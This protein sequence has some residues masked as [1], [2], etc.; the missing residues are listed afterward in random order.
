MPLDTGVRLGPYEIVAPISADDG[1]EVYKAADTEQNRTVTIKLLPP[2]L[3]N[4]SELRQRFEGE[5]KA[6]SGLSHPHICTMYD[7]RREADT[8]FLVMEYVEGETLAKRLERGALPLDEALK[9]AID[10]TD[11][12][13]RAHTAGLVHLSLRPSN[14]MLTQEGPKLLDFGM[15]N[16]EPPK[17]QG[18]PPTTDVRAKVTLPDVPDDIVRYMAPEQV[19]GRTGDTRSDIFTFGAILYEM[20]TDEKAFEGRNRAMLIAAI[21]SLDPY[22]L[23]K[24]QPDSPPMLDH[25]AQRCLAKDPDGRWQTAHDLLVQMRWVAEGG[26]VLLAAARARRKRE[27]RVLVVLA[28][29]LFL[30][31]VTAVQAVVYWGGP[32]ETETFQFRVPVAGLN[33]SD[34]AISPDGKQLAV[35]AKPNTQDAAA[36]F[37]RPTGATEFHRLIG[38]E[39][40][41]QPFW[42]PDSR[43]IG[44]TAGGRLKRVEAAG[45]APKDLGEAP[46]FTGGAWGTAGV[47]LFGS[48]KGLYRVSAEGGK[49][50][51]T[52][53]VEKPETGHF[54]PSF[55]PDGQHYLY[56]SWSVDAANRAVFIGKLG[57]KDKGD[58]TKLMAADSNAEYADP[59]YVLFHRAATL[60]AQRFD[61]K[62][63]MPAGEPFHIADQVEFSSTNGR[64]NFDVS[65]KGALVYF[66]AQGS[67]GGQGGGRGQM[68]GPN[69]Q[70]G[71]RDRN[72]RQLETAGE[73]GT[74][75]DMDLSPDGKLLAVTQPDSSGNA[76]DIWVIDWQRAGVSNR[77]TL[78]PADDINPV[79][80]RPDGD[81]IAFTTYRKGNADIYIKNA[82]GTGEETPLL[83]TENNESIE[84]WSNDG[85]YIAYK[86]GPAGSEDIWILPL[87]GDKKPFPIVQGPFHKDEPQFSYDG[88]WLAYT[89]D[90]SGGTYQVWVVS[91]PGREQRLQVSKDGGGQP[92]W[93]ADGKELFFRSLDGSAMAVDITLSAKLNVAV[94]QRLFAAGVLSTQISSNPVRHQWAVTPDGQRFLARVPA[95]QGLTRGGVVTVPNIPIT[96]NLSRPGQ[97]AAI[98]GGQGFV[99]TGLTVIRN[100]P[101]MFKKEAP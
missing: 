17:E 35:I 100:W 83:A 9:V 18:A 60:F 58:K 28:A 92:R 99:S 63:L 8:D 22:P 85:K 19:E 47:I 50:E 67:A 7:I 74:F 34:I 40:A 21:A 73:T 64:G 69:F 6:L 31:T 96:V 101:A 39:D 24:N 81:R 33:T 41:S 14:V 45:G 77:L 37:V 25:I 16:W 20:V 66:Q 87:F 86:Q 3:S 68:V 30:L 38:T 59:G 53:A 32:K 13:N 52:T 62:K 71:W 57:A 91:F 12:L 49:P 75:G 15:A 43:S 55:L 42:S 72:G 95:T 79:W 56:L 98:T 80:S 88:K 65:Q 76:A 26:D 51:P 89:S 48:A 70:W 36:L 82:N 97:P 11:A 46:G 29:A 90:E 27:R 5:V 84:A 93:R 78:D 2:N 1:G 94:P 23:S 44:F 10:I 61:A 4:N 54:W